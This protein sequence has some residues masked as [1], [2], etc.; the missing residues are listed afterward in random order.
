M[1]GMRLKIGSI[2][3]QELV[4]RAPGLIETLRRPA[5]GP[6]SLT[7]NEV[8]HTFVDALALAETR[9]GG[10]VSQGP[11]VPPTLFRGCR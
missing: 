10:V 2:P 11:A 3:Q 4:T 6:Q 9:S 5:R 7:P 8:V 1:I